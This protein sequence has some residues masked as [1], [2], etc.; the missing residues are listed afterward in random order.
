[1]DFIKKSEINQES[2]SIPKKIV[3]FIEKA[4]K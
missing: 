4:K 1:M 2:Y 3:L